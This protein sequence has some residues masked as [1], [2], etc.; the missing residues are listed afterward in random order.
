MGTAN[1]LTIGAIVAF[2]LFLGIRHAAEA[3]H[4]IAVTTMVSAERRFWAAI[5]IAIAWGIG[6]SAM[7]LAVGGIIVASRLT[8][9]S[10][11]DTYTD[12]CVG[13]VL[14]ALGVWAIRSALRASNPATDI[15]G[16]VIHSHGHYHGDLF[17]AHPHAHQEDGAHRHEDHLTI[18]HAADP[19]WRDARS[20][21]RSFAVGTV[22]GMAG[23]GAIAAIAAAAI[24]G[25]AMGI[26]YLLVFSAGTVIGMALLASAIA[27]PAVAS[28]ERLA[29]VNR[30]FAF[31][32]GLA[33]A[34]LG[35]AM[36]WPALAP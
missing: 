15:E 14:I 24:P 36:L 23:S 6:H 2:G 8:V 35:I 27:I 11:F 26:I 18:G 13:A 10:R 12:G 17:H 9:P 20:W 33:A 29:F 34:G 28:A 30:S 16:T 3:D 32:S 7:I 1:H 21:I 22:H 19:G 25:A 5:R 31:A 4:V